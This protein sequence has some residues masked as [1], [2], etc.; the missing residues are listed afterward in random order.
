MDQKKMTGIWNEE[1][2]KL[3]ELI[4]WE[5]AKKVLGR[6][7]KPVWSLFHKNP[8]KPHLQCKMTLQTTNHLLGHQGYYW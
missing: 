5:I 2:T 4:K 1:T 7:E 3:S 6:K 8:L